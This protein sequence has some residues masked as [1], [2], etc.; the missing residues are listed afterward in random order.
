MRNFGY[1]EDDQIGR[2][3]DLRLWRRILGFTAAHRV[4]VGGAV[5]LSILVTG[6]TLALPALIRHGID[7]YVV[8]D[9]LS[10]QLRLDGLGRTALVFG[11]CLLVCFVAN[12]AQVLLLEWTG[13]SVMHDI[14][15]RLFAHLLRLDLG[16]FHRR[17][18]GRLVTRLTNDIQNMHEM[19]TS[20]M[21]TLFNDL[22]KLMGIVTILFVMNPRLALV[23]SLFLPVMVGVTLLF[24]RLA[25]DAYR[26]IRAQLASLNSALQEMVSGITVI[27]LYGRQR[28]WFHRLGRLNAEYLAGT[29]RQIRI[30]AA[31]MPLAELLSSAAIAL[32]IWYGGQRIMAGRLT[33]G[34]LIAFLAYMRLFFQPMRELSQKYS[35]VQSAMA[36]AERIFQLLDTG[37]AV[38]P[39]PATAAPGRAP[40]S[41][42]RPHPAEKGGTKAG[43]PVMF[44][45]ITFGYDPRHPVLRDLTLTIGAGETVAVV[46]PSGAGKTTL[47]NLVERLYDPQQGRVLLDGVDLREI[48]LA[49]LRRAIGLVTQDLVLISG[50]IYENVVMDMKVERQR[51]MEVLRQVHLGALVE[52]MEKGLETKIGEGAGR[53]SVGQKQL[54]AFARI[55]IRDPQVLILDEATSS[56]DTETEL[57]LE[58]VIGR[59]LRGRTSIVIAHRLSTVRR[60]HRIVVLDRGRIREQGTHR[61]LVAGNGIYASLLRSHRLFSRDPHFPVGNRS[62]GV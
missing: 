39:P 51:V 34:E 29:L 35:I 3:S 40:V 60:A 19:F 43:L 41:S 2:V 36:S 57:L 33:I 54:I 7:R 1:F 20:V 23:M 28:H 24:S 16:F 25:R 48:P 8:A 14:R 21:V 37:P 32:I 30:F 62:Q 58:Q 17:P 6:S 47:I 31:F 11:V 46:G 42:V 44:E 13:Q 38:L 27:Q 9:Q 61:Q 53:L 26:A 52:R 59:S 55:L 45:N 5:L 12:F 10:L 4:G 49:R 15:H 56:V 50:S 22:L 18:A